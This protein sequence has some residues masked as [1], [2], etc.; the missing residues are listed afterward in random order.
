MKL[1]FFLLFMIRLDIN[2][3]AEAGRATLS[4]RETKWA[5]VHTM[6]RSRRC[7]FSKKSIMT[8]KLE[9]R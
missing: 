6:G 9:R 1:V 2:S 8:L 4:R 5:E 3:L 7:G